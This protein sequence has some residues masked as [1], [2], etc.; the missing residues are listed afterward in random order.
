MLGASPK[1]EQ[2][3]KTAERRPVLRGEDAFKPL[4]QQITGGA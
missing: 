1:Q 3:E 2:S 4:R